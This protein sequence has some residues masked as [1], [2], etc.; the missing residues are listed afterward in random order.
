VGDQETPRGAASRKDV[1]LQ[2]GL[3]LSSDL[4]LPALLRR[5]VRTA[6]DISGAR[7]GALG[8]LG[9][10]GR[11][12]E[13]VTV[14]I[15]EETRRAI[16]HYPT[17]GGVLG[18]LIADARPLR[19]ANISDDPRSV[20][21]PPNHPPMRS[22]LGA[23]V[24][25][26]G[27]V[28]G[29]IYLAEK[30]GAAEFTEE[31]EED[32]VI[33][34]T[35]AGVAVANAHLYEETRRRERWLDAVGEITASILAGTASSEVLTLA[36]TRARELAGADLATIAVRE[37]D[38]SWFVNRAA[39]GDLADELLGLRFPVEGSI[40]GDAIRAREP[41]VLADAS[42]DE[43]V[44]QPVVRLGT[45]G[46][47]LVVPMS[48]QGQAFGTLTVANRAPGRVFTE[49][50]IRVV[51]S[52]AGQAS[53]ALEYGR[54]QDQLKRLVVMEDRERIAKELHDGVIQSLF[55][56]GMGLQ[57]T[58][59]AAGDEALSARIE[60]AVNELDRVIRDLRNYIF[61]LR[62]GILADRQLGE[63]LRD[64][65]ED[66]AEK[67]GVTAVVDIDDR[68][69]AELGSKAAD[70]VQM[71]REA[72]SN[73]GRHAEAVTC[74]VQLRFGNDERAVL[75]IDDDGRGFDPAAARDSG[76]GLANLA[77][78]AEALGGTLELHSE[79]A[80]GTTV[81]VTIPL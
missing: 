9:P 28:Y 64:L 39:A 33:L 53:I 35:Q 62:P 2:A 66:F 63:A 80:E 58:A 37:T 25:A 52:F 69:A 79:P 16:G 46:P 6:A 42:A 48:A 38:G 29:N 19:L 10:D 65:A 72:L 7:Y 74:R 40:S 24:Q 5:I 14:G 1:L 4:S 27:R 51:A 17:G 57:G 56:V 47:A 59:M 81:R 50:D 13:F 18:A 77:T 60:T 23:P 71:T 45:V 55:A 44:D 30:Q 61:G 15:D 21:F 22:F 78:R 67:T 20:G 70:V 49:D 43:R 36:A 31:D 41:Q 73:V 34:A 26:L 11:I 54:A 3:A 75:E 32:L 8:V 12:A 76:N 68:V